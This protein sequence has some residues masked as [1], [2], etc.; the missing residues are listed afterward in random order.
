MSEVHNRPVHALVLAG[1]KSRRMGRDKAALVLAGKPQLTQTVELLTPVVDKVW[2]SVR[3]DQPADPLRDAYP[4]V[5]DRGDDAG[6]VA[7]ILAALETYPDVD[8]LV[9]AVDLPN[10]DRQTLHYLLKEASDPRFTAFRSVRDGL[11]E[12]LCA[13]YRPAALPVIRRFVEE[14][15]VC[16]RKILIRSDAELLEQPKPGAL[17]NVNTPDDLALVGLDESAA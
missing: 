17:E 4:Q 7:G 3:R 5:V 8:W 10:L 2:V 12:P 14:G 6:P 15:L 9:V 16:P 11:P 1:G 13:L